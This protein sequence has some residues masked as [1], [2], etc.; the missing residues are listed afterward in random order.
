MMNKKAIVTSPADYAKGIVWGLILAI[1]MAILAV[2]DIW[3]FKY[4]PLI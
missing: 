4:V 3:L 2:Y 1:I